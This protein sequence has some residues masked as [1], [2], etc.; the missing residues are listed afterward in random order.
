MK[1]RHLLTV[2][3]LVFLVTKATGASF[4]AP[5]SSS[6]TS[7]SAQTNAQP[8]PQAIYNADVGLRKWYGQMGLASTSVVHVVVLGNSNAEGDGT[9]DTNRMA[10]V[11][12]VREALQARLGNGGTGVIPTFRSPSTSM[13][14]SWTSTGNWDTSFT[15]GYGPF[16]FVFWATNAA[17]Y[18]VDL[19][20]DSITVY[21]V[22]ANFGTNAGVNS[23]FVQIDS[24][25]TSNYINSF[26]ASTAYQNTN[27]SAGTLGMHRITVYAPSFNLTTKAIGIWG[28]SGN[29]GTT[30]VRV[31][32]LG[33]NGTKVS[34]TGTLN[35]MGALAGIATNGAAAGGGP[36]LS[37]V[38][39]TSNDYS[40]QADTNTFLAGMLTIVNSLGTN[41]SV[42]VVGDPFRSGGLTIPQSVYHAMLRAAAF[43]NST[44]FCFIDALEYWA[45]QEATA[46][47]SDDQTH[48]N[49]RG[50]QWEA[51]ALLSVIL[52]FG[53]SP[54]IKKTSVTNNFV[55]NVYYTNQ[56]SA[57]LVGATI[58]L[59]N[60]L[61]SDV[62]K[63]SLWLDQDGDG[64]WE[65]TGLTARLQGVAL[66]S[67]SVVLSA[68]VQPYA[69]FLFT[70]QSSS[71]T[72]TVDANSSQ[73]LWLGK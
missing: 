54:V 60:V 36:A 19:F 8:Q 70:N 45:G 30:G 3:L 34:D 71:G 17:T 32:N 28:I 57:A 11:A 35:S 41:G 58:S 5:G 10:Y 46:G 69:R 48:W 47:V 31:S 56:E 44:P 33:R 50:H 16:G 42:I 40:T 62:S 39:L 20:C 68:P 12:L 73:W 59:T 22:L 67:G 18:Y 66:S 29:I 72:A 63:V 49:N 23:G 61:A 64:I 26:A 27:F 51:Q 24:S 15:S 9:T 13:V 7:G 2:S 14:P 6:S 43:T 4:V 65:R 1:P 55:I 25:S 38:Q 53:A 37:I 21:G 52:P